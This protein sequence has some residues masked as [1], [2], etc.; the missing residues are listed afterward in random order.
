[1]TDTDTE[2]EFDADTLS[3]MQRRIEQL[4]E[5][6]NAS[7]T[8]AERVVWMDKA[9][10]IAFKYRLQ[11]ALRGREHKKD[12][13]PE[14]REYE[15]K[16]WLDFSTVRKDMQFEIFR[17][18]GIRVVFEIDKVVAVGYQDDFVFAEMMWTSVLLHFMQTIAPVWDKHKPFDWN[19]FTIKSSGRSWAEIVDMAPQDYN[20]TMTSG[21]RL[22]RAFAA[23][24]KRRGIDPKKQPLR[25]K[26]WRESFAESYHNTLEDRLYRLRQEVENEDQQDTGGQ[27]MLAL[28]KD[29]DVIAEELYQKYP[30]LRPLTKEQWDEYKAK[31]AAK[32]QAEKEAYEAMPPEEKAK[33]DRKKKRE[34]AKYERDRER[35]EARTKPD[36]D[37]WAAG[38]QAALKADL[39]TD[40][41]VDSNP[42]QAIE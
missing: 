30:Y 24:A 17:F 10:K 22:R 21:P 5:C 40:G 15:I 31:R 9:S 39:G 11:F 4:V 14:W 38:H 26:K 36:M 29:S 37:G 7:A 16:Y 18:H 42:R 25:P 41:K 13:K 27:G 6:A 2:I 8:E 28:R 35:Y 32:E 20:L 19:V 1:M 12:R 34:E 3:R 23:E 33:H